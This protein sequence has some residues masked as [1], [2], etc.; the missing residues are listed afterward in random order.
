MSHGWPSQY[1][2]F[3]VFALCL[4][5]PSSPLLFYLQEDFA[6]TWHKI[7]PGPFP[8]ILNASLA[9]IFFLVMFILAS[10][11]TL[12]VASFSAGR[13]VGHFSRLQT[14]VRV[15]QR[16]NNKQLHIDYLQQRI[17]ELMNCLFYQCAVVHSFQVCV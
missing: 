9:C 14:F 17:C 1:F 8:F 13:R 12:C 3:S 16:V 5:K 15:S 6:F 4:A 7:N 11:N 10:V 2:T